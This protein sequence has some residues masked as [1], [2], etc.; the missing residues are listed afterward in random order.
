[1]EDREKP[2]SSI[3]VIETATIYKNLCNAN[4]VT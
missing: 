4:I 2:Q 3:F 1:M